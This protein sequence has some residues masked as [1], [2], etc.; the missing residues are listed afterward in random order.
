M[1]TRISFNFEILVETRERQLFDEPLKESARSVQAPL[2]ELA[3]LP[4]TEFRVD[5]TVKTLSIA[6][7]NK[8][9]LL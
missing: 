9:Q 8:Q 2:K 3:L 5:A 7:Q 6:F 1:Q 4:N